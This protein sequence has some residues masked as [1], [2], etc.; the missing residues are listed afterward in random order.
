MI[1]FVTHPALTNLLE[2]SNVNEK[3]LQSLIDVVIVS[4]FYPQQNK[5][6]IHAGL[7]EAVIYRLR[8]PTH[9]IIL[10]S[11]HSKEELLKQDTFGILSLQ[12]TVFIRLP[13]L[14]EQFSANIE[15]HTAIELSI[16]K[17][18]W[19][20]FSTYACKTLLKEKISVIKHKDKFGFGNKSA[21]G[22]NVIYPLRASAVGSL[23]FP[24][25]LQDVKQKLK[26]VK[27]YTAKEEIEELFWLAE[28]SASLP[29]TF[30]Q[31]VSQFVKGFKKLEMYASQEEINI[32]QLI[33]EI[34]ILNEAL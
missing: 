26:S 33:S 8:H 6:D 29:D 32:K 20:V 19:I 25:L 15:K 30:L 22:N 9:Y 24:E 23:T 5:R 18:E 10:L 17:E 3:Y 27:I 1:K 2:K 28:A 11:F 31:S 21:F 12:G 14:P 7:L 4:D 34:D 16:P 13:F